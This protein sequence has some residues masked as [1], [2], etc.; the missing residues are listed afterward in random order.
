MKARFVIVALISL[1]LA[2]PLFGKTYKSTYPVPCGDLWGAVKDTLSN[3]DNYSVEE[4]DDA[5]MTASYKVK[6]A[7]HVTITGAVLQ[8]TNRVTLVPKGTGCEMQVVSNYSG[9]EHNDRD[10]FKKRVDDFLAKSKDAKPSE[11]AKPADPPR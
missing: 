5:K 3:A 6:H 8:R 11:P 1:V 9:F 7:V 10:D 2:L 4:N